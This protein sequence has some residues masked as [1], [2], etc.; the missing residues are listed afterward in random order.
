MTEAITHY[1]RVQP[2]ACPILCASF[3]TTLPLD[4]TWLLCTMCGA[5]QHALYC[6]LHLWKCE[7]T[8]GTGKVMDVLI[9]SRD[10][11]W[12]KEHLEMVQIVL[13]GGGQNQPATQGHEAFLPPPHERA[14]LNQGIKDILTKQSR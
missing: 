7:E 2:L 14:L 10:R 4:M 9:S 3:G 13:Q 6:L 11:L 12:G 5:A 1:P 8:S